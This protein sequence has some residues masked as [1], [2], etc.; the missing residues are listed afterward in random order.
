MSCYYIRNG[1]KYFSEL[2]IILDFI[3]ENKQ[4]KE[5]SIY[6]AEDVQQST[7]DA[8]KNIKDS[9]LYNAKDVDSNTQEKIDRYRKAK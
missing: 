3:K 9:R 8:I 1:Q 4:L 7:I 5:G 6:S 2:D